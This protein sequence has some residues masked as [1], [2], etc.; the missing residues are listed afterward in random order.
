MLVKGLINGIKSMFPGLQSIWS[1]VTN[2]M[3]D[4]MRKK[5]D[6]HSP[7]RVM[8]G[9]G[10]HIVD[11][12]GVGLNNRTPAL[13]SQYRQTLG[14]FDSA[15]PTVG[16]GTK[17]PLIGASASKG[18]TQ[19]SKSMSGHDAWN[20]NAPKFQRATPIQNHRNITIHNSDNIQIH[21]DNSGKGVLHNAA[22]EVRQAL[23]QRDRERS[24]LIR[25]M[26]TDRE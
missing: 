13:Q 25:R 12:I 10:G 5:M 9:M 17:Q 18:N 6:I 24:A 14:V 7:S 20:Q 16:S 23:A 11:G 4:F 21:I 15:M 1:Q 19:P 26:L 22:N 3:P 2:F 8:A